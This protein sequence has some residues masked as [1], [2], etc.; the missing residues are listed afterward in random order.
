[1][2]TVS[3]PGFGIG[4]FTMKEIAISIGENI[5]IRWYGILITLGMVLAILYAYFKTKKEGISLDDLLDI[6]IFTIVFGIIGARTYYV[7]TDGLANYVVYQG[8][9]FKLWDT[10][11]NIIA[12]WNGGIAIY[13][14]LIAGSLAIFFVCR[15]KKINPLKAFDAI[16]PGV[17][18]AQAIG[19]W[20][21]FVNG[22]AYG[23]EVTEDSLLYIFRMGLLPNIESSKVMHYFHPTFLY[24]SVWNIIGF[25]IINIVYSKKKKFDGQIFLMYVTWYGFG[26]MFIEGLRTDSLYVGVFRISQVVGFCC[27]AIGTALL[28]YGFIKAKKV[29]CEGQDYAPVY[30]NFFSKNKQSPASDASDDHKENENK[31]NNDTTKEEDLKNDN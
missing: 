13:G 5:N 4:E 8:D 1:M 23:Y 21:N 14:G 28:I 17:M 19:R 7:L 31:D 9:K 15:H 25:I 10:I 27:F 26:R 22:E 18:I 12:I 29:A 30:P 20:G 3:F 16:A 2:N 6:G 11:Y 24:E